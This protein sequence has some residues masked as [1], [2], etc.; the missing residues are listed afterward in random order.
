LNH[1]ENRRSIFVKYHWKARGE[2]AFSYDARAL[3]GDVVAPKPKRHAQ[4]QHQDN[5]ALRAL[6]STLAIYRRDVILE[7]VARSAEELLRA[8]DVLTAIPRLLEHV[9]SAVDVERAHLLVVETSGAS[10][11]PRVTDHYFWSA[12]GVS[13]PTT[14]HDGRNRSLAEV[15]LGSLWSRLATGKTVAGDTR[16]FDGPARSFF[17][18][19][20]V[21]STAAVPV[22]VDSRWWGFIAFDACRSE[23]EWLPT[24]IDTLKITAELVG[25]AVTSARRQQTLA[26]ANRIIEAS[27]TV[28]YRLGPQ[29]P[30]PLIFV[31]QNIRRYGYEADELLAQPGRWPELIHTDDIPVSMRILTAMAEGKTDH[32]G[33]EL[34]LK[35][36][37]GSYVWFAG[38]SNAL[39]DDSG[40]L[41]AIEGILTNITERKT[42]SETL[43]RLAKTDS[44]TGLPNRVAF[45]DRLQLAFTR[46]NRNQTAFSVFYLDLDHFKDVNDTLGHP[47]GDVLLQHVASRLADCV[48]A[49]DVVARLGGDEFAVLQEGDS[50]LEGI[51]ALATKIGKTLSHPFMIDG[52]QVHTTVSIGIVPYR[53]GLEGPE[54][55]MMKA[56]LALYRAKAEGR[57]Q[58]RFHVIELDRQVRERMMVSNDMHGAVERGEFELFYQPQIELPSGRIAGLEAL[59]R[60]NHPLRGLLL[61]V[62]FIP[63]AESNG[64]IFPIGQ[65]VIEQ[66]CRQLSQWRDQ[67]IK[68]P[69]MAVNISA[70]Q[71]QFAGELDRIVK[72]AMEKYGV[73][74]SDLELELTETVLMETTQRHK[75]TLERLHQIGVR[76]AIDDFGTGFSSLDYLRSFRVARL[77]LA[78]RFIAE[79]S[80]DPDAAAIVRASVGLANALGIEVVAEGV[81]TAEQRQFLISVGCKY[82][83][84]FALGEPMP[85]ERVRALLDHV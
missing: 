73:A 65:W 41:I 31:S 28:V 50:S 39:R 4:D 17:E 23:R 27:P 53:V 67:G 34:R 45:I 68:P 20:G 5:S 74:P 22:F 57:N 35:R 18:L 30:Y 7:A 62:D 72:L 40:R 79:V 43:A 24:E 51:E 10:A 2:D 52:N 78:D 75:A 60:W 48:R 63:V 61:P 55:M 76:L 42:A 16:S 1:S 83:Q 64:M 58:Y 11:S 84:G 14:F 9:A 29:E 44:L 69:I 66:A 70:A 80:T 21:K 71:F 37:D 38:E 49:S 81:N 47:A 32:D 12:P 33:Q 54:A 3:F 77:K 8:N 26:D 59:I 56:D 19:G 15:G 36:P 25:A 82:A 85:A 6:L 46:A 13:T